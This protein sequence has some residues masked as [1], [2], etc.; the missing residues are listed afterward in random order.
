M[1]TNVTLQNSTELYLNNE[2]LFLRSI[3]AKLKVGPLTTDALRLL[4][5]YVTK[6]SPFELA[7]ES[8]YFE[9][10][11]QE[12][13]ES[14][15]ATLTFKAT[16]ETYADLAT[17]TGLNQGELAFV[18]ETGK[19]YPYVG[20]GFPV[21][22]KG[23]N[24]TG[25]SA[26]QL[27]K[28]AGF[29]GT[30]AEWLETLKLTFDDLTPANI[31]ALKGEKGDKGDK[32]NTGDIGVTGKS[33][34]QSYV[35]TTAEEVALSEANWIASLKGNKGDDGVDGL[36]GKSAYTI[37]K[38]LGFV[39][40]ETAWVASLKGTNGTN[41]T[42]GKSAYEIY[43]DVTTAN[44]DGTPTILTEE[45]WLDSLHGKDGE[46]PDL[47]TSLLTGLTETSA[48]DIEATDPV[49]AAFAKLQAQI[50]ALELRVATLENP[51]AA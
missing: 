13:L 3:P 32:G 37:A 25:D 6:A 18:I 39:G 10:T 43:V 1:E 34:Y 47:A 2:E 30:E 16:V 17:V 9:G 20:T 14:L 23:L 7:L 12:W 36:D 41:G 4:V 33:A 21:E 51:P 44:A 38:E 29:V 27:A 31:A 26:Y 8:G 50:K 40:D 48:A 35:D 5:Y 28:K 19:V 49:L 15:Q 42:N 24:I 22:D 46:T 45:E 11:L